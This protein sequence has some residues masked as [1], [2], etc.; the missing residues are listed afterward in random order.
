MI[1]TSE[2]AIGCH[3]QLSKETAKFYFDV[4]GVLNKKKVEKKCCWAVVFNHGVATHLCVE[5]FIQCVAK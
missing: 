2:N 3:F 5:S 4:Y 1:F